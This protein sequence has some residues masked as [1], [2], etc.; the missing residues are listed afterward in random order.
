MLPSVYKRGSLIDVVWVKK[1]RAVCAFEVGYSTSIYSGILRMS[2]LAYSVPYDSIKGYIIAPDARCDKVMEQLERPAFSNE[3]TRDFMRYM[4]VEELK[5]LYAL[6][7]A[8]ELKAET[9][10]ISSLERNHMKYKVK[11]CFLEWA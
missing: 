3:H 9:L 2:D 5:E 11:G 1:N 7:A 6:F 8:M 10:N 4:I